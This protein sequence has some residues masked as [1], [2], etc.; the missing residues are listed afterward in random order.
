MAYNLFLK[1][2]STININNL[3]YEPF[4]CILSKWI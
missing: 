2:N 1:L 4:L 3:I